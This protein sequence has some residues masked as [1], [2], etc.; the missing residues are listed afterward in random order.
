MRD[1]IA[2]ASADRR[3]LRQGRRRGARLGAGAA[4][5]AG[6]GSARKR[7]NAAWRDFRGPEDPEAPRH[8]AE[9]DASPTSGR[10]SKVRK[11]SLAM[12]DQGLGDK[13]EVEVVRQRRRARRAQARRA[14]RRPAGDPAKQ[15]NALLVS[16][17]ESASGQP[18]AVF[19]PQTGYFA[20]QILMEMDLHGPGID[21]RGAA[22]KGVN[23]YVTL[24]RGRDYAWSATSS[25]QDII[26]TFAVDLCKPNGST[27]TKGSTPLHLPRPVPADGDAASA[28][29]A[30]ARRLADS[31]PAGTQTLR[32][33]RT[34]LGLVIAPRRRSTAS[35]WPTWSCARRTCTRSTRPSASPLQ[36]PGQD[37]QRVRLPARRGEL[38]YTFNWFYADDTDIAYFNS[39]NNP[40]R[41]PGVDPLLPTRASFEWRGFNP[42]DNTAQYIPFDNHP[43]I[44][45]QQY[46]ASWNNKPRA[47]RGRG[48]Q[49]GVHLGVPRQPAR[50]R[51]QERHRGGEEDDPAPAGR[52]DGD[53]RPRP[54]CA[55]TP[56]CRSAARVGQAARP[57]RARRRSTRC[58]P[59][60]AGEPRRDAR[61][62][63]RLRGRE[64]DRDHGRLVAEAAAR[65]SSSR[66]WARS[67]STRCA[68]ASWS[69]T[70][71]TTTAT[72]SARP[73]RTA[74]T[75]SQKDLRTVLGRKR[76]KRLKGPPGRKSRYSRTYCGGTERAARAR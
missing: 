48:L 74:G 27:P 33:L 59:G 3:D 56:C 10:R 62:R 26:D 19:G 20:P 11:G 30:G 12:P 67:S 29:T 63:Q 4:G 72:T 1:V 15:S 43:Q 70:R 50:R 52:R 64:R 36:Q 6:A 13:T 42:D 24:G 44:V 76:L 71:R 14:A 35:R 18:I 39:G 68:G 21:A 8:G 22:F 5:I 47:S 25:G 69:T 28:R 45:N 16:A 7:G 51:D 55:A 66:S 37:R 61:P 46:L 34:K 60:G 23:L 57:A 75:A 73:T 32:A 40:V 9:E 31:T 58:A 41:P 53:G 2:T 54:T 65:P 49:L 38:G 17:R